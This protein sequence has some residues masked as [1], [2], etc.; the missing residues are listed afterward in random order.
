MAQKLTAIFSG[1]PGKEKQIIYI[2]L[3]TAAAVL[4]YIFVIAPILAKIGSLDA[5]VEEEELRI[6]KNLKIVGQK[7][8]IKEEIEYYGSFV[9]HEQSQEEETVAFLQEVEERA[10]RSSL[11]VID[12]KSSGVEKEEMLE[13]YYVKL[14]CEAQIEQLTNF[15]YDLESSKKLL[16]VEQYDI[17]PKTAGSS[18][19]RCAITI[20]KTVL[21]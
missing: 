17:R 21:P 1:R 7:D 10:N 14:N 5:Q 3:F 11:Y 18:I 8:R 13:K 19:L 4:L 15:L 16:K 20:S 2:V 9:T 12:I 6:K